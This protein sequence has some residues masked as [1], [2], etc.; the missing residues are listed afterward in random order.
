MTELRKRRRGIVMI[1]L[2]VA[3]PFFFGMA[4]L[5]V[6]AILIYTVKARL[7]TAVDACALAA[8]RS[9]GKG[10]T[11]VNRIVDLMFNSNF[12]DELL[13]AIDRGHTVPVITTIA[14]EGRREVELSGHAEVPLVFMR[15]FG[16]DSLRVEAAARAT[17]R[18]VNVMLIIDRSGSLISAGAWGPLQ[19]AA[20]YFV[21]QFDVNS[22]RLG[23]TTFGTSTRVDY[24]IQ[25][26]RGSRDFKTDL[27]NMI[28]AH[29][30]YG[31]NF[32]NPSLGFYKAY[33]D[34]LAL[35]EPNSLN[36]I[37]FFTDGVPTAFSNWFDV[38]LCASNPSPCADNSPKW[39]TVYGS[40]NSANVYGLMRPDATQVPANEGGGHD[41]VRVSGTSGASDYNDVETLL[42]PTLPSQGGIGLRP[43]RPEGA[44]VTSPQFQL[45]LG[46]NAVD[47]TG[48]TL[49][50]NGSATVRMQEIRDIA[51]N[52]TLEVA[53]AA[54]TSAGDG[55]RI[56]GIGLGG[57]GEPADHAFMKDIAN[58]PDAPHHVEG[59]PEGI[60][61][62]SPDSSQLQQ[63]F[64]TVASEIF[65]LIQ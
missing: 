13:L 61:Y 17:R 60:Y 65:R 52:V 54:R 46:P 4:G 29:Q 45:N 56:Y 2:A 22:D 64:Q 28:D 44:A 8:A 57:W 32:T 49:I 58:T 59:E 5:A 19:D 11:E 21:N 12:P 9:L 47:T 26:A 36:A 7:V 51:E 43:F 16:W 18:D 3:A 40:I 35:G 24:T 27:N 15:M 1:M 20:K 30:S 31:S 10:T 41:R 39:G 50:S 14:G 63:A 33:K 23:L 53:K 34:I 6:D 62:Y 37:V 38:R 42:R 55:I 48:A 25:Y